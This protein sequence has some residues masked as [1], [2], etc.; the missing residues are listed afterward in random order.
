MKRT[1]SAPAQNQ[2][3]GVWHVLRICS[4]RHAAGN[5]GVNVVS[6]DSAFKHALDGVHAKDDARPIPR[7]WHAAASSR[8]TRDV[9]SRARGA[10]QIHST[11]AGGDHGTV[12][13]AA[14]YTI[15]RVLAR[16]HD[17][18]CTGG[19]RRGGVK[20]GRGRRF[21]FPAPSP[22]S[23][24]RTSLDYSRSSSFSRSTVSDHPTVACPVCGAH[25]AD[26]DR[27]RREAHAPP[28]SVEPP[29]AGSAPD[30]V[31][32]G[33]AR[34]IA[35]GQCPSCLK[36]MRREGLE[37]HVASHGKVRRPRDAADT[38]HGTGQRR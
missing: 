23:C 24:W 35:W 16:L 31:P 9:S 28:L 33:G 25:V 3:A 7:R 14:D 18:S 22:A 30:P 11:R 6:R 17:I 15:R 10:A 36:I 34:W 13:R 12:P 38:S 32:P 26:A 27:H 2:A 1:R 5:D 29:P 4:Q 21:P 20:S 8:S 37:A 19:H